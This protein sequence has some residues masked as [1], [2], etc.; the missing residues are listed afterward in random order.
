VSVDRD[1]PAYVLEDQVG[2]ILRQANQRHRAIFSEGVDQ[3]ILPAQFVALAK[4]HA[5]GPMSQN[6]LGRATAMDAATIKGVVDRLQE[7][8]NVTTRRH[9]DDARR[10][11]VELT[12]RGRLHVERLIPLAHAITEQTLDPLDPKERT[13]LL[14]LLKK[15][16]SR[17]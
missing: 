10:L 1:T 8:R 6:H 14:H 16:T 5:N 11:L 4:L 9:P 17:G 3:G 2:F 13:T 12:T 7:Q 15:I